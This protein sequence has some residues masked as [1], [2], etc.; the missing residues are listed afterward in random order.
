MVGFV[1]DKKRPWKKSPQPVAESSGVRIVDEQTMRDQQPRVGSPGIDAKAALSANLGHVLPVQNFKPK[2]KPPLHLLLPLLKH[3]RRATDHD[4][5][6]F[7]AEQKLAGNESG[8]NGLSESDIVGNK[9]VYARQP[10]CFAERFKL[11]VLNADTCSERSLQQ[12]RVRRRDTIPAKSVHVCSE[13]R[14]IVELTSTEAVPAV[15]FVCSGVRL[16]IPEDV[17]SLPLRVILYAGETD[18]SAVA[19]CDRLPD[20]FDQIEALADPRQGPDLREAGGNRYGC[21]FAQFSFTIIRFAP[22][23]SASAPNSRRCGETC[24]QG[25]RGVIPPYR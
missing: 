13:K 19:G 10:Q 23:V 21:A 9:E 12:G 16:N 25:E 3:G 6:G 14:R 2:P 15:R 1:E 18:Q 11:V 24:C 7:F 22:W 20:V 17:E 5:A 4:F 8:L